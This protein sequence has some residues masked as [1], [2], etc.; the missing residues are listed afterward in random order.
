MKRLNQISIFFFLISAIGCSTQTETPTSLPIT[1]TVEFT[2]TPSPTSTPTTSPSPTP[3]QVS[4]EFP[5]WVKNPETQILL[6]PVGMRENGYENMALFNAETGE[7]FDVPVTEEVGDY[8]WMPDGLSFGYFP[9]GNNELSIFSIRDETIT[10]FILSKEA[11]RFHLRSYSSSPPEPIQVTTS[12]ITSQNFLLVPSWQRMSPDRNYFVFQE[13]YDN[14]YTS[15]FD[16]LKNKLVV[17]SNPED[18][19]Y[20]LRSEFSPNS[21]FIAI[22]EADQEPGNYT[23]FETMPTIILRIYDLQSQVLVASYKNVTF[24]IWSPDGT[25]FLYQ[26]W[27]TLENNWIWYGESPPCIFDTIAETTKCYQIVKDYHSTLNSIQT[28]FYSPQWSP[29][30]EVISYVYTNVEDI[31]YM[32]YGGLCFITLETSNIRCILENLGK[33]DQSELDE[34]K[35]VSYSWSPDGNFI[36]FEYDTSGPYSDDPN[37]PMLGI[38]NIKTGEYFSLGININMHQLGVWRPFP[39]P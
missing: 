11:L 36:S 22:S 9:V 19:Y 2:E 32:S 25:K 15:I 12:D 8:F 5:E 28:T 24:P 10:T 33:G 29:N 6:V 34:K 18:E 38:A 13:E 39:N 7:K 23:S 37:R 14:T 26:E 17:I 35:V 31:P 3:E 20:D 30:Q 16:V 27:Q 4:I 1:E 21:N